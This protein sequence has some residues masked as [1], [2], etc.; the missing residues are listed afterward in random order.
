MESQTDGKVVY[1]VRAD[2]SKLDSDLTAANQKITEASEQTAKKQEDVQKG[3]V[4]ATKQANSDIV[5][6]TAKAQNGISDTVKKESG[7][8]A[9]HF[10]KNADKMSHSGKKAAEEVESSVSGMASSIIGKI[11][12]V[13]AA[14]ASVKTLI[15]TMKA[16]ISE[17][18][19]A[20]TSYA[21]V[22]TLLSDNAIQSAYFDDIKNASRSTGVVVSDLSE[23]VYSALSA[24]VDEDSAVDFTQS[25]VKL[26]KGGF[27]DT[28][29]AVDV[30]TTAINAYELKASEATRISDI[31]ITTQNKGKT[32]VGELASSMGQTIPIAKSS[33]TAIEDLATQYAVLTK[34]GVAT[35]ESGTQ[36]KAMLNEL[37][38]AGTKVNSTLKELTG[39]SFDDLQKNGKNTADI[40]NILKGHAEANNQ[41]LSDMFG[42]VEAGAAALTLVKDGGIDFNNTLEQMKNSAGATEKAY[43]TMANTTEE[44]F[45]KL[46]NN[47]MIAVEEIGE[48]LLPLIEDFFDYIEENS[49]ELGN[50]IEDVG[51]ALTGL[52]KIV[53]EAVK[54]AWDY[55]DAIFVCV[56]ALAAFKTA[57]KIYD[58]VESYRKKVKAAAEATETLNKSTSASKTAAGLAAAGWGALVAVIGLLISKTA[59]AMQVTKDY[60]QSIEN[61]NKNAQEAVSKVEA[62]NKVLEN[63][64]K[65]YDELRLSAERT[66]SE[67]AELK[68]L[69]SDLQDIFGDNITVVDQ[70][71]G[72]Y[73]DLAE[74]LD[75]YCQKQLMNAQVAAAQQRL[76]EIYKLKSNLEY[77]FEQLK[78]TMSEAAIADAMANYY[79][80]PTPE[81]LQATSATITDYTVGLFVDGSQ[82]DELKYVQI[83]KALEDADRQAADAENVYNELN[84]AMYEN[85]VATDR[86]TKSTDENSDSKAN[87][88]ATTNENADSVKNLAKSYTDIQSALEQTKSKYDILTAATEEANS[89]GALSVT[90]L[91]NI[92]SAYPQLQ[93]QIDKYLAGLISEQE[94]LKELSDAYDEDQRNYYKYLLVKSGYAEDFV[95]S[96]L[97]GSDIIADYFMENYKIDLKNYKDYISRKQAIQEAF[98]SYLAGG[99]SAWWTE[100]NGWS[101]NFQ[102]LKGDAQKEIMDIVNQYKDAM[103]D[104]DGW[105]EQQSTEQFQADFAKI[106][107]RTYNTL[108]AD[109]KSTS[110]SGSTSGSSNNSASKTGTNGQI[111][112]ITSYIPTMW[113]D[114]AKAN[115]KLIAGGV[116]ASLVGDSKSGKLISGL[117]SNA[118]AAVQSSSS[119][120]DASLNDVVKAIKGLE[121]SNSEMQCIVTS[122]L[123][124][125]SIAL[126]RQVAKGVA[127]IEKTTGKKV[128]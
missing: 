115:Q 100:E 94:L 31:L 106:K 120:T 42:S 101:D 89:T 25:A 103:T 10:K 22:K 118:A 83:K 58:M 37:N 69:A 73:N 74:A 82:T 75:T 48:K 86:N 57:L 111:I 87:N 123:N 56:A 99:V 119:S 93:D 128:F 88:T 97:D 18:V 110:A 32:T 114:A 16:A 46:K 64:V 21:K 121:Q 63:K 70:L 23:A 33:N 104:L 36:I 62:E 109:A 19:S 45:N 49:E 71:T 39:K 91:K 30:L 27:T 2:T 28:A 122:I 47:L 126:A 40:L 9:E 95:N 44:R 84:Q 41:K 29:T 85:N 102:Y 90:T 113:D 60:N 26:A 55:R 24:S 43:N 38:S 127:T 125:D 124:V 3:V 8:A 6:D 96:A 17:A 20:E 14:A 66:A 12:K 1:E 50:L 13:A 79:Y 35:A 7:K 105:G 108:N 76:E 107:E 53:V 117:T 92:A 52:L 98:D 68:D 51:G 34:N 112:S 78:S 15:S 4:K 72:K 54:T 80:N 77:E 61:I 67:E 59:E 65:R 11:G 116:A 81:W 5:K